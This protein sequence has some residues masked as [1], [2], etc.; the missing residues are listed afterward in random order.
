MLGHA[1]ADVWLQHFCALST[2]KMARHNSQELATT[3]WALASL[4]A[5]PPA[6]WFEAF[7]LAARHKA[8]AFQPREV[9][10]LMWGLARMQLTPG[11]AWWEAMQQAVEAKAGQFTS[12]D[13]AQVGALQLPA[14]AATATGAAWPPSGAACCS[15]LQRQDGAVGSLHLGC[16]Y[17]GGRGSVG[18]L[19]TPPPPP[20]H[21]HTHPPTPTHPLHPAFHLA[22]P[23]R[24]RA[25]AARTAARGAGSPVGSVVPAAAPLPGPGHHQR[26]VGAGAAAGAPQRPVAAARHQLCGGQRQ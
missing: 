10:T 19:P 23:E 12:R 3:A 9:A 2:L 17:G 5:A 11:Q 6:P 1:P 24:L 18:R 22:G 26:P 25:P 21:T 8:W 4:G 14:A 15:H 16:S 20:P 7:Q 13:V